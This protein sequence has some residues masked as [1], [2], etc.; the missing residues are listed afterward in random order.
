MGVNSLTSAYADGLPT[1]APQSHSMII[2]EDEAPV[3]LVIEEMAADLGWDIIG[4]A[5][6][7]AT[8]FELLRKTRPTIA[9]LDIHLGLTTSFAVAA[10]CHDHGV[11]V[12]FTTGYTA[13][14]VP[15]GFGDGPT[16]AKPFSPEDLAVALQRCLR[17]RRNGF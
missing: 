11:A 1:E 16:L 9:V 5:Q 2:V 10:A 8:A 14:S 4:V 6:T 13:V 17:C 12:L 7:E 15:E 3:L